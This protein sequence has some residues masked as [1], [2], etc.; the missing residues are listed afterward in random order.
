MKRDESYDKALNAAV[1]DVE[2]RIV[3]AYRNVAKKIK[4]KYG[5]KLLPRDITTILKEGWYEFSKNV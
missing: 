2:D 5:K 3:A 4:K 1:S